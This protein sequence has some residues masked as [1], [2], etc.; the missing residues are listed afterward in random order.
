MAVDRRPWGEHGIAV[1]E[2]LVVHIKH[3]EPVHQGFIEISTSN[4]VAAS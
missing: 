4:R 2:P 1:A 3:D